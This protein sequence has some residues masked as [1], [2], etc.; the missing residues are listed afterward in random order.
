MTS[1]KVLGGTWW[2]PSNPTNKAFGF[3]SWNGEHW[4]L[5]V[6]GDLFSDSGLSEGI[7]VNRSALFG[8]C[9][10]EE[11]TLQNAVF[12]A[13]Q[14]PSLVRSAPEMGGTTMHSSETWEAPHLLKGIHDDGYMGYFGVEFTVQHLNSWMPLPGNLES[15]LSEWGEFNYS[16]YSLAEAHI[17]M[18]RTL[19]TQYGYSHFEA[20]ELPYV[21]IETKSPITL[22]DFRR[23]W[24]EPFRRLQAASLGEACEVLNVQ[25][26][27]TRFPIETTEACAVIEHESRL[28]GLDPGVEI[29]PVADSY[30]SRAFNAADLD[31]ANFFVRWQTACEVLPVP[32]ALFDPRNRERF[33][34][35]RAVQAVNALEACHR[36]YNPDPSVGFVKV[37][38]LKAELKENTSLSSKER[39]R[40]VDH[41]KATR[42]PSL[43][44]RLEEV[45]EQCGPLAAAK[46]IRN[47]TQNWAYISARLRNVLS[48][49][50]PSPTHI[51]QNYE[52]ID[53]VIEVA[54]HLM[55]LYIAGRCGMDLDRVLDSPR[56][57]FRIPTYRFIDADWRHNAE[58]EQSGVG[59]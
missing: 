2:L 46:F 38:E 30:L 53:S 44:Q 6:L 13:R 36:V 28:V 8:E 4:D 10:G 47:E 24:I 27:P 59:A 39:R 21:R 15:R 45:M 51:K 52:L 32:T 7:H 43:A 17:V 57:G 56:I 22:E 29:D 5:N 40:I 16:A 55:P 33:A 19:S 11:C 41:Y 25:F 23:R 26:S 14:A 12:R 58:S 35:A 37:A 54:D 18:G 3:L 48:H 20:T 9:Y 50:L 34:E 42:G 1:V 49:G 31:F